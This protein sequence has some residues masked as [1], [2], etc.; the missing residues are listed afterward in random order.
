MKNKWGQEELEALPTTEQSSTTKGNEQGR[1][2]LIRELL[3]KKGFK[4]E[5]TVN[6]FRHAKNETGSRISSSL[7]KY[8]TQKICRFVKHFASYRDDGTW[9]VFDPTHDELFC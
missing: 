5:I 7:A 2:C 1:F 8:Y 3:F 4:R 9:E 6:W